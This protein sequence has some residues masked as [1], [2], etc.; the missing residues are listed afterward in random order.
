MDIQLETLQAQCKVFEQSLMDVN[1][2]LK[3]ERNEHGMF[4]NKDYGFF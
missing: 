1:E 4:N 2:L 3:K